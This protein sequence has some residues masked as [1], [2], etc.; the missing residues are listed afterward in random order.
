MYVKW[1]VTGRKLLESV[2]LPVN[3]VGLGKNYLIPRN[4]PQVR[5]EI[6]GDAI[7]ILFG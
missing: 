5:W 7:L 2:I 4:M 1:Y 3:K 6:S